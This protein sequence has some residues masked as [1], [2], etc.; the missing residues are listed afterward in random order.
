MV[1]SVPERVKRIEEER[2]DEIGEVKEWSPVGKAGQKI[3]ATAEA[4][5]IIFLAG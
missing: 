1:L 3:I 2:G 4:E 5:D